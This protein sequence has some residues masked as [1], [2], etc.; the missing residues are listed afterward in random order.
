[1]SEEQQSV[2]NEAGENIEIWTDLVNLKDLIVAMVIT[3][4][5]TLGAYFVA[6]NVEPLPMLFGLVGAL[7]GFAISAILIKPKRQF[8]ETEHEEET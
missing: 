3:A 7:V 5:T 2:S 8:K 6:P 4:I 1:M